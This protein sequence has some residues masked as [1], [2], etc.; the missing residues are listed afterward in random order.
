MASDL[1]KE[2]LGE[3]VNQR[4]RQQRSLDTRERILEAAFEEFADRGFE[5]SSTRSV[6]AKAGVQHPL[7]TYHFKNKEGLW[8]AVIT[9]ASFNFSKYFQDHLAEFRSGG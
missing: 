4:R 5:G 6:A 9:T 7:V 1:T 3:V 2:T 8:R